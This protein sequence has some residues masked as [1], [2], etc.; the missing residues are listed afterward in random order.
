M[1]KLLILPLILLAG[2]AGL[3]VSWTASYNMPQVANLA[4]PL[5]PV[6]PSFSL[7]VIGGVLTPVSVAKP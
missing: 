4:N 7:P 1:K 5:L 6:V 2:C 3:N